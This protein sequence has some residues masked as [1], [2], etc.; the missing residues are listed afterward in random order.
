[1]SLHLSERLR[2]SLLSD[3][4]SDI[5]DNHELSLASE[6]HASF[7]RHACRQ[8][9]VS[10]RSHSGQLDDLIRALRR[11][12]AIS[13]A[14]KYLHE[15]AL[16]WSNVINETLVRPDA[17]QVSPPRLHCLQ[18]LVSGG[19]CM[20]FVTLFGALVYHCS[21]RSQQQLYLSCNL[22]FCRGLATLWQSGA[23]SAQPL[24]ASSSAPGLASAVKA[25]QVEHVSIALATI[26]DSA[27]RCYVQ[28]A[29]VQPDPV[30][31]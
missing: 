25:C 30:T 28:R 12:S 9:L 3:Q 16:L 24:Q 2:I 17:S 27:A 4:L 19:A 22:L 15:G 11:A 20:S 18:T 13:L 5:V 14:V 7:D 10:E 26:D 1:M 31:S 21:Y 8:T 6:R 29:A 23:V